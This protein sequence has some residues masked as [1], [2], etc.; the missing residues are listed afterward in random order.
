MNEGETSREQT[1]LESDQSVRP[2]ND[3]VDVRIVTR[4]VGAVHPV[5]TFSVV[6]N[7]EEVIDDSAHDGHESE[8]E[9]IEEAAN[10]P[11]DQYR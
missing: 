11:S 6:L 10:D 5:S 8:K 2:S 7:F 3:T 4:S 1:N 9:E